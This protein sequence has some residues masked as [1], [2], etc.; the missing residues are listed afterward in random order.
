MDRIFNVNNPAWQFL[1][2][3]VDATVLNI[4]WLLCSL[5]VVTI[6]ASTAALYHTLMN[7]IT[8][9]EGHYIRSYFQSFRKNLKPGLRLSLVLLAFAG[10]LGLSLYSLQIIEPSPLWAAIRG[11]D[12]VFGVLFLFTLQYVFILFGFFYSSIGTLIQT[13]FFLSIRHFGRTLLM[14]AVPLVMAAL[15]Y[16]LNLYALLVLGY[17][18]VVYLDCYIL[19]PVVRPYI[20]KARGDEEEEEPDKK[21]NRRR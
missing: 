5:P 10:L 12:L 17:G 2:K 8:D 16:Y 15:V 6:G 21:P 1:G 11:I 19:K 7:D 13:S 14:L 4:C 3:I 20:K 9:E 18:F